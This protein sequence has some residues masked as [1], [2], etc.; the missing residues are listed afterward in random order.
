M[1]V[2]PSAQPVAAAALAAMPRGA[3]VDE[4]RRQVRQLLEQSPAFRALPADKQRALSAGFDVHLVKPVDYAA[5][6]GVLARL[7]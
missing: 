5:L 7:A 3:N 2:L 6:E 1:R 4:V